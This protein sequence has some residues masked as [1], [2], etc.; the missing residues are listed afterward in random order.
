MNENG[1]GME[2]LR[3]AIETVASG[4]EADNRLRRAPRHVL[5]GAAAAVVAL[6]AM[7][8]GYLYM[9]P[10][11]KPEVKVL[12]LK[13]DGR[14]VTARLVDG[15]APATIIVVPQQTDDRTF[16]PASIMIG[17]TE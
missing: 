6:A 15:K 4:I 16:T 13:I 3:E 5:L 11:R 10:V 2:S 7:V 12:V 8:A 9:A 17:G 1:K 14:A